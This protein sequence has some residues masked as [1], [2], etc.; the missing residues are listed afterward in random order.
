M[1]RAVSILGGLAPLAAMQSS[2]AKDAQPDPAPPNIILI[3]SDNPAYG[4]HPLTPAFA[5]GRRMLT[6]ALMNAGRTDEAVA[7]ENP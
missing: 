4:D 5:E 6:L 2:H 1:W 7:F 3:V